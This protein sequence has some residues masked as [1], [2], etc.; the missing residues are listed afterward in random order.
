MTH[1]LQVI[2]NHLK[3]QGYTTTLEN[4]YIEITIRPRH[5]KYND[6]FYINNKNDT[7]TLHTDTYR[8]KEIALNPNDPELLTKI[9]QWVND[10]LKPE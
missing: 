10:Q 7:I 4:T 6:Y 5:N 3:E 9:T 8:I 1:L 2:H